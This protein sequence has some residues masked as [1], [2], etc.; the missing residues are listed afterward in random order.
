MEAYSDVMKTIIDQIITIIYNP[1]YL[2]KFLTDENYLNYLESLYQK[3]SHQ[4]EYSTENKVMQYFKKIMKKN[5]FSNYEI[6]DYIK[7]NLV[8]IKSNF[9]F[10][11]KRVRII[12]KDIYFTGMLYGF[13]NEENLDLIT[14]KLEKFFGDF[15]E[16]KNKNK[17]LKVTAKGKRNIMRITNALHSHTMITRAYTY[18]G[19]LNNNPHYTFNKNVIGNFYQIGKR[20][21]RSNLM[22]TMIEMIWGNLFKLNLGRKEKNKIIGSVIT[23]SKKIIDNIM[24][25]INK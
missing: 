10:Y 9:N 23:T 17:K 1:E 2:K 7:K 16:K 8:I 5:F 22:M 6:L 15:K 14:D 3:L 21:L 24:V 25:N 19:S 20:D 11:I 13:Y 18:R 12:Q 4:I